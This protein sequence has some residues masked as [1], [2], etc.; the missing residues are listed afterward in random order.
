MKAY[1][2]FASALMVASAQ[3]FEWNDVL[4]VIQS[5][6]SFY[7]VARGA[8]EDFDIKDYTPKMTTSHDAREYLKTVKR[9]V[10]PL[11]KE[12]RH[13]ALQAHHSIMDR[14]ERMGLPKVGAAAGPIVGQNYDQLTSFSGQFL[15]L[16][17]G[18][19]YTTAGNDSKCYDA[20]E[21][22]IIGLDTSSDIFAKLYIPAYW[23]ELQVQT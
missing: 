12:Q 20:S 17:Q 9:R 11:T 2:G 21:S 5:M 19:Q 3:A 16:L 8:Y 7:G 13:M 22:F 18:M 1:L 10:K 6:T 14:R 23:S 15:N 4:A